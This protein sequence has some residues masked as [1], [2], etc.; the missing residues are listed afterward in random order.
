M[1]TV[2][3]DRLGV[4]PGELM[5]D[6]GAGFGRHAYEGLRRGATVI[7]CD[8]AH[9]ELSQC[10]TYFH[11]IVSEGEAPTGAIGATSQTDAT[12]LPFPDG[13]FDR[14][15]A[16]EVMEHIP[17]HEDAIAELTRVLRPGGT[18]AVTVPA[19]FPESICWKLN[20][21]FY[22]PK[23]VGGHVRI[24][25][26]NSMRSLLRGAGLTPDGTGH[27]HALHSPYWWLKC[28]VGLENED[29]PAVKAYHRFLCWDIE[30]QP[31]ITRAA[32]RVLNP[33]LGKSVVFYATKP[34]RSALAT[35]TK[36][37][38]SV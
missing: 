24:Y 11:A 9:E 30:K 12:L 17:A 38:A 25:T 27:A 6:I 15:I 31:W 16:S 36:E 19:W 14:I 1:L 2:D 28:A 33:L 20:D 5:L 23:A 32:E 18:I 13:T 37:L 7:A 26:E 10:M 35:D 4:A 21:E 34:V 29:H 3:Y 22:A 8:M